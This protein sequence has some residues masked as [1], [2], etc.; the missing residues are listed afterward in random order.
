MER[1]STLALALLLAAAALAPALATGSTADPAPLDDDPVV[2][3]VQGV[4]SYTSDGFA[5][6]VDGGAVT[7]RESSADTYFDVT[8][9]V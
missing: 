7:W 4:G 5:G 2:V 9:L 1:R 8:P 3:G 6:R